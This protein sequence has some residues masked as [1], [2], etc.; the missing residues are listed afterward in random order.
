M[1]M[2]TT[3]KTVSP[4]SAA[5]L[6]M[7]HLYN[8]AESDSTRP[9]VAERML[10]LPH[11]RDLTRC[12]PWWIGVEHDK[13]ACAGSGAS[14][15][16]NELRKAAN[17]NDVALKTAVNG[18]KA[19]TQ[20]DSGADSTDGWVE[21]ATDLTTNGRSVPVRLI[22]DYLNAHAFLHRWVACSIWTR[23]R[24]R[25][26]VDN[27]RDSTQI[28]SEARGQRWPLMVT[29]QRLWTCV[30][31]SSRQPRR[32]R[33]ASR[34][35]GSHG[36]DQA[37]APNSVCDAPAARPAASAARWIC[38]R[39][40]ARRAAAPARGGRPSSRRRR[41]SRRP[42]R[43]RRRRPRRRCNWRQTACSCND[44]R[45]QQQRSARRLRL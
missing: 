21:V 30:S 4:F 2:R 32:V 11:G 28:H 35:T 17:A 29:G 33:S 43:R 1:T 31:V 26:M 8:L 24:G 3:A 40:P 9:A 13:C 15:D 36:R 37:C 16:S 41:P 22:S 10:S 27:G 38:R 45:G 25:S 34:L 12:F 6:R 7:V 5:N 44:M 14:S 39:W 20:A 42:R 18:L 19:E 23:G